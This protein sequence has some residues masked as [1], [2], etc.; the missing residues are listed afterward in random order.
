[1]ISAS[2]IRFGILGT[3]RIHRKY[4][5]AFQLTSRAL[6]T[7]VASRNRDR[8]Q[9]C[10]AEWGTCV[11]HDGYEALVQDPNVD[12]V[13]NALHNGLHCEWTI[14]ALEAGKHVLCEKPLACTSDEVDRMFAAARANGRWLMEGFM[15]R[16]HPQIRALLDLIRSGRIGEL[17]SIRCQYV[18]LSREPDNPRFD[19]GA[20]G[21][22][23]MD[24]GC[25]TVNMARLLAGA[26]PV[27][28]RAR[29]LRDPQTGVDLHTTGELVF[30]GDLV[31]T[32]TCGFV[33]D[34]A[35]SV[36]VEG[37]EGRILVPHPWLPPQWPAEIQVVIGGRSETIVV[38]GQGDPRADFVLPFTY[39]IEHLCDC[40]DRHKSP[41]FPPVR[42]AESD[43]RANM[44]VIEALRKSAAQ[45]EKPQPAKE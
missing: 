4:R 1:V 5:P 44:R 16:F 18:G 28:V 21:G 35:F 13:V 23:L 34:M 42:D 36:E 22:A 9:Q 37:T 33:G 2:A 8:A 39:E 14:R 31:A 15:Y 30:P 40:I 24:L 38:T 41:M 19:P 26:E 11:G 20:G 45:C 10:A 3:G 17:R 29:A 12:A 27:D 25:Y 7:A 43:S 32:V 6:V